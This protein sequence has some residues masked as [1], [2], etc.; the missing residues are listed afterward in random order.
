MLLL[1]T[2]VDAETCFDKLST[3]LHTLSLLVIV[4]PAKTSIDLYSIMFLGVSTVSS[5][6]WHV[7]TTPM[8]L[9]AVW[10]SLCGVAMVDSLQSSANV[11]SLSSTLAAV[12]ME[13]Q[14]DVSVSEFFADPEGNNNFLSSK[15]NDK[16]L[17]DFL[18]SSGKEVRF[19][20]P[21]RGIEGN[22]AALVLIRSHGKV[23][24]GV[25]FSVSS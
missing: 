3:S 20:L 12:V 25:V 18:G 19:F 5:R 7:R 6:S 21:F 13:E 8:V 24:L 2:G 4:G 14:K 15:S 16:G 1:G 9:L 23:S 11:V 10:K 17:L 22:V